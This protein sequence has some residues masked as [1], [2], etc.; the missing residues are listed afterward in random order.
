[1]GHSRR[2]AAI[3]G[4]KLFDSAIL[5]F[6]FIFAYLL[7]EDTFSIHHLLTITIE[8]QDL[9]VFILLLISWHWIFLFG[10][11]YQ[12]KR[13]GHRYQEIIEIA[14]YTTGCSF[15]LLGAGFLLNW[16]FLGKSFLIIFWLCSTILLVFSRISIRYLLGMLRRNG[17]DNRCV[18]IVGTCQKAR[19]FADRIRNKPELGYELVG[20]VDDKH[21]DESHLNGDSV[22]LVGSFSQLPDIL[23]DRVV[24]EV[25]IGLPIKSYYQEIEEIV[26][27]C[28]EHGVIVRFLRGIF[29]LISAT[30]YVSLLDDLPVITLYSSPYEDSRILWKRVIDITVSLVLII[31]AFPLFLIVP[32]LIKHDSKGPAYFKQERVGYNKRKFRLIKFRTMV[33]DA[34]ELLHSLEHLNETDGPTFKLKE[35]PRLTR[36]GRW[37][38][39]MSIDELP[40]LFN[41]LKG[42]MSL[43]GPRPLPVRDYK[44]F[45]AEWQRKRFSVKPGLTC[46]WQI[47]GRST[48]GFNEWMKLDVK[49]VDT[50]SLWL[51]TKILLKTIPTVLLRRGAF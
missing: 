43:V 38:R 51:D 28:E 22:E 39:K 29:S 46:L 31:L 18:L 48:I 15:L 1:M 6:S 27:L 8:I 42:D 10:H 44:G 41:V 50:W 33:E 13:I 32:L 45:D 26:R 19:D 40:Q 36:V 23:R 3:Q 35:D 16:S 7:S 4:L 20:F 25:I 21:A 34:E 17:M 9:I 47:Q 12:S 49:Y 24:D 14:R 30:F 37:L 5:A 2:A 11:F